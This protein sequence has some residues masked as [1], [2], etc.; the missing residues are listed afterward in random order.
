MR[1]KACYESPKVE[2]IKLLNA[3]IVTASSGNNIG[4]D[5]GENDGEW[6]D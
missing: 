5:N 3:D 6:I 4:K 1:E 2:L